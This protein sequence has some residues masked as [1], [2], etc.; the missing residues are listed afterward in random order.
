MKKAKQYI[1]AQSQ[2]RICR[3][4]AITE[5]MVVGYLIEKKPIICKNSNNF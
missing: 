2:V 1:V 3:P 5:R 4:A